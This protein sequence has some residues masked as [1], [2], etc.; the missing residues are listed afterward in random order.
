MKTQKVRESARAAVIA[1][2]EIKASV[3]AFD[4]GEINVFAALDAVLA[5]AA[6]RPA[7]ARG[8][9][10]VARPRRRAA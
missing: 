9:R 7:V 3:A 4:R 10:A 6:D 5:A 1:I 8:C 2:A